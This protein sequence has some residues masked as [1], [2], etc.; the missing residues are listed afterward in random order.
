MAV[1]EPNGSFVGREINARLVAE[2]RHNRVEHGD[3]D[4]LTASRSFS[5]QQRSRHPLGG[6]H[7]RHDV[8][9]CDAESDRQTGRR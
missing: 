7:P 8:S 6:E 2:E 9:D 4:R 3:V 1:A 5:S